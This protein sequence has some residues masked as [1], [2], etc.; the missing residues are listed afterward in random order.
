MFRFLHAADVHLDS[1]LSGLDR[2][3]G[4]P[5]AEIRT[6]TR[7][8]FAG[9]IS[10]AVE[11]QVVDGPSDLLMLR[12]GP[13]PRGGHLPALRSR[14]ML[15]RFCDS[16]ATAFAQ[17]RLVEVKDGCAATATRASRGTRVRNEWT[18]RALP[19][20]PTAAEGTSRR[21]TRSAK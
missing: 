14:L 19:P 5:A 4:A 15:D 18:A 10:L 1:P 16:A 9:L 3:E 8:A 12:F 6:A 2:Y 11:E 17:I 13:L 7:R 20:A 21:A